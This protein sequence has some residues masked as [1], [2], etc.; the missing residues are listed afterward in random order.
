MSGGSLEICHREGWFVSSAN[1]VIKNVKG[2]SL[3]I[4][5]LCFSADS[6]SVNL[7]SDRRASIRRFG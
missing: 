3:G 4:S 7:M 5:F 6:L 1:F 2:L